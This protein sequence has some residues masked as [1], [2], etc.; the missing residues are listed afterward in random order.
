ML[1]LGSSEAVAWEPARARAL[2]PLSLSSLSLPLAP[3]PLSQ[4]VS[5]S[6]AH[7]LRLTWA[8]PGGLYT[9]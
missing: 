3:S 6:E 7:P 1:R 4:R 2:S 9:C 5:S 8:T